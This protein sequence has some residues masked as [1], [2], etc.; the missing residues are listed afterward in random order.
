MGFWDIVKLAFPYLLELLK[1]VLGSPKEAK[2]RLVIKQ[3][4]K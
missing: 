2:K 3:Q 4:D 1:V